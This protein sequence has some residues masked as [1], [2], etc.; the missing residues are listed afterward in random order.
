MLHAKDMGPPP[1]NEMRDVGK[2]VV[3]WR[4]IF[5]H[6]KQAGLEYVFVENDETKNPIQSITTSYRY[7]RAL[8]FAA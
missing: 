5:A 8:R 6:R 2:G 3:D 1:Q 4:N 7:L